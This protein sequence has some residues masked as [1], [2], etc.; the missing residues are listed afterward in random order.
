[1][2]IHVVM[3]LSVP[4]AYVMYLYLIVDTCLCFEVSIFYYRDKYMVSPSVLGDEEKLIVT[5]QIS[6]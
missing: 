1:M 3:Y 4:A 5:I 6:Y 2:Y